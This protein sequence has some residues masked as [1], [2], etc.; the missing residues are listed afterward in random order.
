MD[1][2]LPGT[3]KPNSV[4]FVNQF[5]Q[6]VGSLVFTVDQLNE[7]SE[8]FFDGIKEA[9]ELAVDYH[10]EYKTQLD[11]VLQ[12]HPYFSTNTKRKRGTKRKADGLTKEEIKDKVLRSIQQ[13]L[14]NYNDYK[15]E[16]STLEGCISSV[17]EL[18]SA[19][20]QN[21]SRSIHLAAIQGQCVEVFQNLC[22]S[23]N[24]VFTKK[25]AEEIK[26]QGLVKKHSL[27]YAYFL[28]RLYN[29][30]SDHNSMY[31]SSLS[32]HFISHNFNTIKE[33][34]GELKMD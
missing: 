30:C 26:K 11:E 24:I 9:Y 14:W 10:P 32:I 22:A 3:S 25:Y 12:R 8:C 5:M 27:S 29:L 17:K 15:P 19:I 2:Q 20:D 16:T 7:I 6:T 23:Q 34:C 18:D 21:A 31:R 4:V 13:N 1:T 28:K 33:I